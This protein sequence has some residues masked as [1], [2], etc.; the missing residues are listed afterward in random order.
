MASGRQENHPA[1]QMYFLVR[2]AAHTKGSH[3]QGN[4]VLARYVS[5][6]A[7]DDMPSCPLKA[8]GPQRGNRPIQREADTLVQL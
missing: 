7:I 1:G 8:K 2:Q 5:L 3:R 6:H 4:R